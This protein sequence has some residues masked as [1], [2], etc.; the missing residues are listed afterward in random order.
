[1][2]SGARAG[3]RHERVPGKVASDQVFSATPIEPRAAIRAARRVEVGVAIGGGSVI[4][5]RFHC[6]SLLGGSPHVSIIVEG[7]YS[8]SSVF[9]VAFNSNAQILSLPRESQRASV[10]QQIGLTDITI[11]YSRPLVKGR[12]IWG[13]LEPFGSVW[14][15]GANENTTIEFSDGERRG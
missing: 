12:K 15:A 2:S 9:F 11:H 14:R 8:H 1:M 7:H 6:L 13:G 3:L 4:R 10:S 5:V